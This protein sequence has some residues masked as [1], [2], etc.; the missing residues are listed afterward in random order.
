MTG[1]QAPLWVMVEGYSDVPAMRELLQRHFA[2]TEQEDF[3]IHPHQ[4]K[5]QL[6]KNVLA[7]PDVRRRGLLDQLPAKL[8][9]F[10][11]AWEG[12]DHAWVLV[13]VDADDTPWKQIVRDLEAMLEALPVP[14]PRVLFRV[15]VEETESWFIADVEALKSAYPRVKLREIVKIEP[16]AIVGAAERLADALGV[17]A[18]HLTGQLKIEWAE[19]IVPHLDF[20]NPK[21]PSLKNL[22]AGIKEMAD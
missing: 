21:S 8:R 3:Q 1:L 6:P 4:G 20:D 19:K 14:F 22:I 15:A 12:V 5:G 13:V 17:S 16:D 10:G 7:K 11:K 9:A 2:L 18:K